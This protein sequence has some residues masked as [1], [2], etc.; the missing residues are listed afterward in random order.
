M[1]KKTFQFIK[2]RRELVVVTFD[3][4]HL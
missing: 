1:L 3:N 2:L 4:L